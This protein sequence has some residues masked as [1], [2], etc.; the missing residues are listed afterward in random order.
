MSLAGTPPYTPLFRQ[1][2]VTTE[3]AAITTLLPICTPAMILTP[4]PI[5]TSSSISIRA[6]D[7][8]L[9]LIDISELVQV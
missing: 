9:Y 4:H 8:G 7:L 5:H 3:P 6:K 2:F 1:S